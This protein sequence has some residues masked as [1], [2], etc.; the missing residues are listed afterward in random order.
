MLHMVSLTNSLRNFK[1]TDLSLSTLMAV[2]RGIQIGAN[3]ARCCQS[4][5][6]ALHLG[7]ENWTMSTW[8][9]LF[10]EDAATMDGLVRASGLKPAY[11]HDSS[12]VYR[13]GSVSQSPG[14]G[15]SRPTA[16]TT[17]GDRPTVSHVRLT[18]LRG[19]AHLNGKEGI[20]KC[21]DIANYERTIVRLAD[22]TEVHLPIIPPSTQIGWKVGGANGYLDLLD[23]IDGRSHEL[24][25]RSSYG[26]GN[27]KNVWARVY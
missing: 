14:S 20:L 27:L 6:A 5:L 25:C 19:A 8:E 1:R 7:A 9:M 22:G 10:Q 18:G 11:R 16:G 24:Q 13:H 26:N 3:A 2:S 12:I 4:Q 23:L 17:I 21:A 15:G